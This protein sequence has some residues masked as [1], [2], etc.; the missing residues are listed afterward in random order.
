MEQVHQ[1]IVQIL[2]VLDIIVQKEAQLVQRA[3]PEN[4]VPQEVEVVVI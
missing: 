4:I 3:V 1:I 2:V